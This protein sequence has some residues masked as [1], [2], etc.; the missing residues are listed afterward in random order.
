MNNLINT[1]VMRTSYA[2]PAGADVQRAGELNEIDA[3]SVGTAQKD[4]NLQANA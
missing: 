1:E 4:G 2:R 3:G